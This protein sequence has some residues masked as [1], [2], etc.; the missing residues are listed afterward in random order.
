MEILNLFYVCMLSSFIVQ[1]QIC[2][3]FQQIQAL[4]NERNLLLATE[5]QLQRKLKQQK[6][7][8]EF[9]HGKLEVWK[10]IHQK[11]HLF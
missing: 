11:K 7:E 3:A 10:N 1:H 4:E 5:H 8:G 6:E 9:L 2:C